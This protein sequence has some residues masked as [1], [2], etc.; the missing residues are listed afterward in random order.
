MKNKGKI[1]T[2]NIYLKPVTKANYLDCI[3]LELPSEQAK[4]LA[5]NAVTIAQSKFEPHYQLRAIYLDEKVIG[6]LAFC[7]EDDPLDLTYFWLFRMMI[8]KQFQNQG[9]SQVV[10]K[11]IL[12]EFKKLGAKRIDSMCKPSNLQSLSALERF[13]FR[14][15]GFLDDG[16]IHL[17]LEIK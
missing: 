15:I 11:A 3:H 16:D 5:S 9:Y 6:M 8:A 13:G 14:Q 17:S 2:E 4:N 10:G 7:H 12:E 1:L